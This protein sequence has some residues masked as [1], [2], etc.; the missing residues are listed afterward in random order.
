MIDLIEQLSPADKKT[1]NNYISCYGV[2][3]KEFIGLDQW[4]QNWSHSNQVLYKLLGNKFIHEVNYEHEKAEDDLRFEIRSKLL[5]LPFRRVFNDFLYEYAQPLYMKKGSN[6]YNLKY[7]LLDFVKADIYCDDKVNTTIKYKKDNSK[8]MLQIQKGMKPIK[9]LSKIIDYFSEEFESLEPNYKD[10]FEEFRLTHS[11]IFN[12]KKIKAKLCISIHPLDYMTMSDNSLNWSSCMSWTNDGCYKI[13]SIEM[14]NSNN[15]FC[16]YLKSGEPY[17]FTENIK[18]HNTWNNKRWRALGVYTKDIILCGKAYPYANEE[19][20]K[21]VISEIKKLAEENLH[22]TYNFGPELYQDMLHVNSSDD[23]DRNR[24]WKDCND[25]SKF[26]IIFDT[27]GMYNDFLNDSSTKYWCYR[28]K[29]KHRKIINISGKAPCLCCGNSVPVESEWPEEYNDRFDNLDTLFC[30]ECFE[31]KRCQW[32][33]EY[34]PNKKYYIVKLKHSETGEIFERRVC[35]ECYKEKLKYCPCC[36]EPFIIDPHI[37]T[38]RGYYAGRSLANKKDIKGSKIE[39]TQSYNYHG[40]PQNNNNF[41]ERV[42]ICSICSMNKFNKLFTVKKR[43]HYK[44][45]KD[46]F[47]YKCLPNRAWAKKY[48]YRNLKDLP[49]NY[50]GIIIY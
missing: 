5:Q 6:T 16:C 11:M 24:W 9:A 38:E 26:N 17:I 28:N 21:A 46:S 13:G 47:I 45:S 19:I 10:M 44:W 35:E 15:I 14:M 49:L 41:I 23:M 1:I 37:N 43:L 42:Y 22:H 40:A 7:N 25:P 4:L 34:A 3:Q 30:S 18:S 36:G 31:E 33:D 12:D 39:I 20:S 8:K 27:K 29:V 48:R 32:C 50:Q 2:N